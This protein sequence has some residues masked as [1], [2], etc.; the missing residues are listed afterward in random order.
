MIQ[1][2]ELKRKNI[3]ISIM[4]I[5]LIIMF[6]YKINSYI[7]TLEINGFSVVSLIEK[8][9][10]FFLFFYIS[11]QYALKRKLGHI[12]SLFVVL[13]LPFLIITKFLGF[14]EIINFTTIV[15]PSVFITLLLLIN[16]KL[17]TF[18]II[19]STSILSIFAVGQIIT[20]IY[21]K[22]IME[23]LKSHENCPYK[24]SIL[25]NLDFCYDAHEFKTPTISN[26]NV[27]AE[28]L[29]WKVITNQ[30][31]TNFDSLFKEANISNQGSNLDFFRS[32]INRNNYFA[33]IITSKTDSIWETKL[34]DSTFIFLRH[35]KNSTKRIKT[36]I[37]EIFHPSDK[38]KFIVIESKKGITPKFK[39]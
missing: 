32:S 1:K 30:N 36:Y 13:L 33:S 35:E 24:Y 16:H 23:V 20:F 37:L 11:I 27:L 14:G 17:K 18:F 22:P 34:L 10:L 26:G 39:F 31:P 3:T 7:D 21:P 4:V 15:I 19:I 6:Y 25:S 9:H 2:P 38:H 28:N 12:Y 29:D 5:W 8:W